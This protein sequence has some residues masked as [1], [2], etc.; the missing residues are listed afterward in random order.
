[1]ARKSPIRHDVKQHT[2]LGHVVHH[3]K[4]GEGKAPRMI[5]GTQ[6]RRGGNYVV[7]LTGSK[8]ESFNVDAGS[9]VA[10]LDSGLE[11]ATAAPQMIRIRRR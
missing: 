9:Y 7:T 6:S 11:H 4:R 2:R 1:L 8:T 5:I 10:A 3:Y